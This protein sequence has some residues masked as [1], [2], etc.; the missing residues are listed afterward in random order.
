[1]YTVPF[2]NEELEEM[3]AKDPVVFVSCDYDHGPRLYSPVTVSQG[4]NV[5]FLGFFCIMEPCFMN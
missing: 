2:S 5:C 4:A 1:M 3:K